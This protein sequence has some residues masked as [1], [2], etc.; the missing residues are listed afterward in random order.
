MCR[1]NATSCASSPLYA[2]GGFGFQQSQPATVAHPTQFQRYQQMMASQPSA[3]R[4]DRDQSLPPPESK[5]SQTITDQGFR[6][7]EIGVG[8][9]GEAGVIESPDKAVEDYVKAVDQSLGD[10]NRHDVPHTTP[11]NIV[12]PSNVP[13]NYFQRFGLRTPEKPELSDVAAA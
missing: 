9:K 6:E 5:E 1:V 8:E 11:S 3:F 2:S 10:H 7:G 4:D 13:K 12:S